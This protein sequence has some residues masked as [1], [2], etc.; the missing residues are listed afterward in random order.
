MSVYTP[1]LRK[2]IV[3]IHDDPSHLFA[4]PKPDTNCPSTRHEFTPLFLET[5]PPAPLSHPLSEDDRKK[6]A[7]LWPAGEHASKARLEKFC[8]ERI[9]DYA[10]HRSEPG[11]DASSC[12]SVHLSQGTISSRACIREARATNTS[13]QLDKGKEGNITWIKEVAWRD[14]YRRILSNVRQFTSRCPCLMAS[15]MS[16]QGLQARIRPN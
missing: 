8:G 11:L 6:F 10:L 12:M 16:E 4:S 2:W 9:Q 13:K 7:A 3:K 5:I 1:W 15:C 14:F